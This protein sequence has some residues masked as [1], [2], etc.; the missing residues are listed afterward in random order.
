[1]FPVCPTIDV[2]FI[3]LPELPLSIFLIA[4]FDNKN[5]ELKLISITFCQSSSFILKDKL[6]LFIP[7][8]FIR[9]SN[10][11][12]SFETSSI[13]F[14]IS[15]WDEISNFFTLILLNRIK[16][17]K[18]NGAFYLFPDI[19]YYCDDKIEKVS[20]SNDFCNWLLDE[21][22]IAFVPGEV[23]GAKGYLRCSYA[24]G[25]KDLKEGLTRFSEAVKDL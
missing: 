24:L 20:N 19:N 21:H 1:M 3:T 14:S 2:I 8:L 5:V 16:I 7:A 22:Y 6:S 11:P 10:P 12:N 17:T 23:F 9:I 4:Y 15:E 18:P 25:E 13:N